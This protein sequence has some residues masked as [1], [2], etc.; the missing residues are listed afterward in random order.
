MFK[1]V[2]KNAASVNYY[3]I[4]AFVSPILLETESELYF[5]EYTTIPRNILGGFQ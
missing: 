2:L 5:A 4:S 1:Y 3:G